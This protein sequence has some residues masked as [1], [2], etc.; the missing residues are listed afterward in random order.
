MSSDKKLIDL[1]YESENRSI[2]WKKY[3]PVYENLFNSYK[4]KNI[5]FVE[6]GIL[7]GGSLEIWKKYFGKKARIIGI[8]NNPECKKFE[9][10]NFEIYIGSQ[11]DKNFWENFY[12]K[13]GNVDIILDDGGHKNLQQ[14]ST[15]HYSLPHIKNGGKIIIEDTITSYLKKEF[16]NPS[17]YSF[18]NYSKN[19]VDYIHR[20]SP[21]LMKDFNFYTK[22]IFSVEFFE[23]IVVLSIDSRKCIKSKEVSNSANNEWA[24][25]YRNNEYFAE[26]KNTLDKKYGLLNKRSFFRRFIRKIFYK[27][28]IFNL[29]DNFKIKK[30][31]R[32]ID[33]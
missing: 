9:N 18:I 5:T 20:R 28:F 17:R 29:L 15:V 10:E 8:D 4:N 12:S 16:Y 2:K 25:D 27:N 33:N 22:K 14:I 6:I 21:L 23:S 26:L 11:S 30:I 24:I 1:F 13:I 7:D 19:I 3:F 31:L 32:N